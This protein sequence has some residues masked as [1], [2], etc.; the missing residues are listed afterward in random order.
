MNKKKPDKTKGKYT[1]NL[2]L[3]GT[4]IAILFWWYDAYV[5]TYVFLNGDILDNILRPNAKNV[6]TRLTV[7]ASLIGVS[8]YSHKL[9]VKVRSAE[10]LKDKFVST[11][12]H[13]LRTP[14]TSIIGSLDIIKSGMAGEISKESKK[15]VGIA[16]KNS[17]RLL[18]LINDILDVQKLESGLMVYRIEPMSVALFVEDVVESLT[19]FADK[20]EVTLKV[21]NSAPG[22]M[23]QGDRARLTQVLTN[24][25]ANAVRH[26]PP[27]KDVEIEVSQAGTLVRIAVIDHGPGVPQEFKSQIFTQFAQAETGKGGTGLGL[28][29][30]KQII[31]RHEGRISFISDPGVATSFYFDLPEFAGDVLARASAEA[32]D[33]DKITGLFN[34]R[35]FIRELRKEQARSERAKISLALIMIEIDGFGPFC[36]DFV[37][38]A[39]EEYLNKLANILS[40]LVNRPGDLLARYADVMFIA[41]LPDTD[42]DGVDELMKKMRLRLGELCMEDFKAIR[43]YVAGE[44]SIPKRF[45]GPEVM[46][47]SV[48]SAL[49]DVKQE[50]A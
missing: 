30:S 12:S 6:W 2:R 13:E 7:M 46:L 37:D 22:V 18:N 26:S 45:A 11:V 39:G 47:E 33:F 24:L 29:I 27:G 49:M 5:D 50:R 42:T 20:Y 23:I 4:I 1:Q 21:E 25:T 41:L 3:I 35:Y 43:V 15:I 28:N 34:R 44:A 32:R 8:F 48:E 40:S 36:E 38:E 31:E 14:L 19:G 10:T 17:N 16:Y 9:I